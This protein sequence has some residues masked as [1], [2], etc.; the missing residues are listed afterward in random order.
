MA[1]AAGIVMIH[2][3]THGFGF[4]GSTPHWFAH[5]V[6]YTAKDILT[7][8]PVLQT[9]KLRDPKANCIS[10]WQ[11]KAKVKP[12]SVRVQ[13]LNAKMSSQN[14]CLQSFVRLDE[15]QIP[16]YKGDSHTAW[17]HNNHLN[18][19]TAAKRAV[20]LSQGEGTFKDVCCV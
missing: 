1:R 20:S 3:V 16:G 2:W 8:T 7:T 4:E 17:P 6:Y 12:K 9:R 13:A 18:L 14:C 19:V 5:P 15:G 11:S 10:K